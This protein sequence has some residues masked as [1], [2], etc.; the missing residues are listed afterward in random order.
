MCFETVR[1]M[2]RKRLLLVLSP[3]LLL[4]AGYFAVQVYLRTTIGDD[5]KTTGSG[6][7]KEGK[8]PDTLGGKKTSALDLRPL[9]VK[10]LQQLLKKSSNGLYD[11]TIGDLTVDVAASTIALQNVT[12]RPNAKQLETLKASGLLPNDVF[13]FAFKN[14]R[15]EGVN[16]D[17]A[18]TSKTMDYK[19]V[20]LVGPEIEIVHQKADRAKS[21]SDFTQRFLKEMKKLSLDK[22]VVQDGNIIVHDRQKG[23]TKRFANVQVLMK[24]ILLNEETRTDKSRFLFAKEARLDFH[25]YTSKTTD[26][27]YTLKIAGVAVNAA[28]KQITLHNLSF[29]S[30]LSKQAFVKKH[31]QAEEMYG[32]SLPSVIITGVDWWS[33]L[34]E[35]EVQANNV[36][37]SGGT[38]RVYFNRSLP[39]KKKFGNFPNQLLLKLPFK[40]DIA[41][42]QIRNL[43]LTYEEYN[44]LSQQSGTVYLDNASMEITNASNQNKTPVVVSGTTLFMHRVPIQAR[45]EFDMRQA[46]AGRFSASIL[47][48]TPYEGSLLN[49]FAAPLGMM[50]VESGELQKLS[51]TISGDETGARGTVQVLYK[52]L[53]LALLEKDK[54]RTT[55]DK[56]DVTSLLA[57]LVVLK[58]DNPKDGRAPRVEQGSY[59]RDPTGGFMMVVWK[60]VLV[61][62]LKSI[63]APTKLAYQKQTAAKQ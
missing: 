37:T 28:Q 49:S 14:L 50:K 21:E 43:D 16:L 38:F 41:R 4:I 58:K 36:K 5:E 1:V 9:F 47:S 23:T 26:G 18:I 15:I 39:P 20:K 10:R 22:L 48:N 32:L 12:V 55:L 40:L 59:Q 34:N 56:K 24:D 25:D 52:D 63:G 8:K 11:L 33:L 29:G 61:G 35:D 42:M 6:F 3:A 44:P 45:F 7:V 62:V 46:K 54:G 27:L 51:A 30:P 53:K 17:D 60:T 13:S 2:S 31:R 19:L 57:N